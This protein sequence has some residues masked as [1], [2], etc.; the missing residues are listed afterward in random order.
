MS[1]LFTLVLTSV[2]VYAYNSIT[3][4]CITEAIDHESDIEDI[5]IEVI[6]QNNE[7][8]G[9]LEIDMDV[10]D[11][12]TKMALEN[13][14]EVNGIDALKDSIKNQLIG[15]DGV[16]EEK[17]EDKGSVVISPRAANGNFTKTSSTY[18]LVTFEKGF[19]V[20]YTANVTIGFEKKNDK[21]TQIRST[22]FNAM[23]MSAAGGTSNVSITQYIASNGSNAGATS[24][25]T[26][27]K[28]FYV[29]I[30]GFNIVPIK[31][32]KNTTD[33]VIAYS[34]DY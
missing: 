34:S 31:Y 5:K 7:E 21:I 13:Y 6:N 29:G 18:R 3:D 16:V 8:I 26:V 10:L 32:S 27:S 24:N 1:C 28:T 4:N 15:N 22:S 20:E 14:I 9:Q 12:E 17:V 11:N 2:P 30:N 23:Y 33:Y 25:Y 19:T